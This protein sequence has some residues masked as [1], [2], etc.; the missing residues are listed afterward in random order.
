MSQI[1]W[2][3]L[4]VL[5]LLA[6]IWWFMRRRDLALRLSVC[7]L[8]AGLIFGLLLPFYGWLKSK[9]ALDFRIA[10]E[11][12]VHLTAD[13]DFLTLECSPL[14]MSDLN[15]GVIARIHNPVKDPINYTIG[16]P[17]QDI[18][19][20]YEP[21]NLSLA[22]GETKYYFWS[23]AD[24]WSLH[25][26]YISAFVS[27]GN[28]PTYLVASCNPVWS[29]RYVLFGLGA[30]CTSAGLGCLLWRRRNKAAVQS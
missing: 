28:H 3:V 21:A 30:L 22:S 16:E 14:P 13:P 24:Y 17:H 4:I 23:L 7:F 15:A 18:V 5:I 26:N 19:V 2:G 9:L 10:M 12:D 29:S 20:A 1:C 27:W 11:Q 6:A 8:T 25:N